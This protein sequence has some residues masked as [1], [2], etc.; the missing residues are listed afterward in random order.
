MTEK[1]QIPLDFNNYPALWELFSQDK[2]RFAELL[3]GILAY[4]DKAV[5]NKHLEKSDQVFKLKYEE[6]LKSLMD[7]MF[8]YKGMLEH[9]EN[10]AERKAMEVL[11]LEVNPLAVFTGQAFALDSKGNKVPEGEFASAEDVKSYFQGLLYGAR[12]VP[13]KDLAN[14]LNL[15]KYELVDVLKARN[16]ANLSEIQ[17]ALKYQE[18][19]GITQ[20]K[21]YEGTGYLDCGELDEEDVQ[22]PACQSQTQMLKDYED[23]KICLTCKAAF[24]MVN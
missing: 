21:L 16:F 20:G 15:G 24:T 5:E 23:K 9:H 12:F 2:K 11:Q 17:P 13:L 22:C 7:A 19:Q 10:E 8:D 3:K 6:L 4:T 1:K 14:Y 18:K